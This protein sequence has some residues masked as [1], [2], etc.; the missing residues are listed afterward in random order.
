MHVRYLSEEVQQYDQVID[1][2]AG[3]NTLQLIHLSLFF[4]NPSTLAGNLIKHVPR[5]LCKS[6]LGFHMKIIPLHHFRLIC[7]KNFNI[8]ESIQL[9]TGLL[10]HHKELLEYVDVDTLLEAEDKFSERWVT[11]TEPLCS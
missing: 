6:I 5:R 3:R 4:F 1:E 7:K 9:C 8:V 11:V 2:V 10:L